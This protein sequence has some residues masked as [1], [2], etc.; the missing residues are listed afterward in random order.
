MKTYSTPVPSKRSLEYDYTDAGLFDLHPTPPEFTEALVTTFELPKR[1]WEPACGQGHISERLKIDKFLVTSTDLKD[2]GYGKAGVDFLKQDK[3]PYG[4]QAIVTNPPFSL[5]THFVEKALDFLIDGQIEV[6]AFILKQ[7]FIG[8]LG[9]FE[10]V[11]S[12]RMPIQI[13]A[14]ANRMK[15]SHTGASYSFYHAWF[16][17]TN[18][19]P[20][21]SRLNIITVGRNE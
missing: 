13:T 3:V 19:F 20:M 18:A 5:A 21:S 15:N 1:I 17:W 2:W 16:V 14:I 4:M 12:R 10:R 11:F 9:R 6:A 7:E 8:S